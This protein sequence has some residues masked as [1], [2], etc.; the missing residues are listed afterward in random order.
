MCKIC[1]DKIVIIYSWNVK[2][3]MFLV[4]GQLDENSDYWEDMAKLANAG[5]QSYTRSD[6]R[7][8]WMFDVFSLDKWVTCPLNFINKI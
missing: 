5:I 7:E 2:G 8:S 1:Y 3:I 4:T 6:Y